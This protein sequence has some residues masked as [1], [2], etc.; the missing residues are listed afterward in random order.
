MKDNGFLLVIEIIYND[1]LLKILDILN[2]VL[3][4]RLEGLKYKGVKEWEILFEKSG[5]Y[6][7]VRKSDGLLM[8]IFLFRKMDK[9][10]DCKVLFVNGRFNLWLDK[11]K[12][13]M[14]VL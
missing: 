2:F 6:L 11:F 1:I 9:V 3:K 5:F 4:E 13:E 10:K 8:T 7:V 14:V 12:E